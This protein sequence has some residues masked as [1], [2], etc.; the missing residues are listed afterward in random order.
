MPENI[1]IPLSKGEWNVIIH[2]VD[3]K[4]QDPR[5]SKLAKEQYEN[6]YVKLTN[7]LYGE[8]THIA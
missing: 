8:G 1:T 5:N 3:Q 7:E 4:R 2:S 6:M